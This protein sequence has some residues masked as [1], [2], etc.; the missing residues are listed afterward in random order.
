MTKIREKVVEKTSI[1][2]KAK[3][4]LKSMINNIENL[5]KENI[6]ILDEAENDKVI[7]KFVNIKLA[8]QLVS[9]NV[10]NPEE[11]LRILNKYKEELLKISVDYNEKE[12][13]VLEKY[14]PNVDK[15]ILSKFKYLSNVYQSK[16][17]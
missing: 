3:E 12:R 17:A 14:I 15:S 13:T 5:K 11:I 16:Y 10:K 9:D 6:E 2:D 4:H 1:N 8:S 7:S